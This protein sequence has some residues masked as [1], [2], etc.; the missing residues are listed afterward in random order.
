VWLSC[1]RVGFS[2]F[3]ELVILFI[4][5]FSVFVVNKVLQ[6]LPFGDLIWDEASELAFGFWSLCYGFAKATVYC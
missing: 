3:I 1:R 6:F 2:G 5:L 4:S